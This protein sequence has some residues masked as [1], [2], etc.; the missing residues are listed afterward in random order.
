MPEKLKCAHTRACT[1][2]KGDTYFQY[3]QIG[4]TPDAS[5]QV[6]S[7]SGQLKNWTLSEL[8]ILA[9]LITKETK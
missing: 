1:K 2:R 5:E 4:T 9:I 8:E 7:L 3:F 6:Q